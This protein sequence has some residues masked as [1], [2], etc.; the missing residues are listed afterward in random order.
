M[1]IKNRF[2]DLIF[3]EK[4]PILQVKNLTVVLGNTP[5]LEGVSFDIYE[6]DFFAIIGPN[7][8]GKTVLMKTILGLISP[9]KGEIII[10]GKNIKE[11]REVIGYVPQVLHFDVSFPILALEVAMMG[12]LNQ[13]GLFSRYTKEDR[14]KAKE[15]LSQVG[16]S[17]EVFEKP[18]VKLSGGQKQRVLIAR[19]LASDPEF[20]FLDEPTASVDPMT[21]EKI[22][23]LFGNLNKAGKTVFMV[24]HDIGAVSQFIT[25]VGCLNKFLHYH[26]GKELTQEMVRSTYGCFVD[27]V[28][29]GLPHRVLDKDK[30]K[31][32]NV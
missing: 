29:H 16:L 10:R 4:T 9:T 1:P 23:A 24:T 19:A 21:N 12:R 26:G 6:D 3:M 2:R 31:E 8:G 27:L 25:K 5:V 20:I 30:H 18:F 13:S 32:E 22:N 7:G 28:S 14:E 17:E 15:A 11:S